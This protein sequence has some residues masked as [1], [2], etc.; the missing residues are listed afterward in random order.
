MQ[1]KARTDGR[2][3]AGP[4]RVFVGCAANGEDLESQAVLEWSIRKNTSLP[5]EITWMSLS[6]NPESPFF[7]DPDGSGPCGSGWR[8]EMWAT[9]FSGFRWAV[10]HLAGWT[11][12]A[13]YC[14]SD[15]IFMASV[16]E[17][18]Q[19]PIPAGRVVLA[20]GGQDWR[21]C[22][23]LWDC[24]AAV[25]HVPSIDALRDDPESHSKMTRKFGRGSPLVAPFAGDWNNL[26]LRD[27]KAVGDPSV[28]AIHYTDMAT[29]PQLAY[30][31]PRLRAQGRT[32]WYDGRTGPHPRQDLQALFDRLLREAT[33]NGY[34]V[35]RYAGQT[36]GR[37][38]RKR[39][40][41]GR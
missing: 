16:R 33:E 21:L 24:L 25:Q 15:F 20:K 1:D 35:E 41:G 18:W 12:R 4:I 27:G 7:C 38:Y 11:G 5:V 37:P 17:L 29:Q 19:Q 34:G 28:K 22:C 14:D 13:I 32:H 39:S 10:P 6:S 23:S 8:T 26:D 30:A 36:L 3:A 9:P 40:F 2:S 31:V